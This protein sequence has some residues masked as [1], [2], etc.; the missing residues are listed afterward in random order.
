MKKLEWYDLK[1]GKENRVQT[2][3]AAG[4]DFQKDYYSIPN[5]K[6]FILRHCMDADGYRYVSPLGRAR[7]ESYWYSL[8]RVF[9]R[10]SK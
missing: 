9:N 2:L 5:S 7:C 8:Q 4:F 1:T 3:I 10:M 6:L